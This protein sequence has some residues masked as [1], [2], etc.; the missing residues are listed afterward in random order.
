MC[1]CLWW[2]D[3]HKGGE[4][5]Q[6]CGAKGQLHLGLGM[7]G[8]MTSECKDQRLT[9]GVLYSSLTFF[10][11][12]FKYVSMCLSQR[13]QGGVGAPGTEVADMNAWN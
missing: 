13:V 12:I 10:L 3:G 5:R 4:R 7:H 9:L 1:G 2:S 6:G 8:H 11:K